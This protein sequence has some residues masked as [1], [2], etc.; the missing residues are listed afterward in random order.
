MNGSEKPQPAQELRVAHV[1]GRL[2]IGGAEKHFVS[3]LNEIRATERW[4]VFTSTPTGGATL[5]DQL[6]PGIEIIRFPVRKRSAFRDVYRLSRRLR[7]TGVNVV[8]THMFWPSLYGVAAARLAGVPVIVTTEHGENRWKKPSHRFLERRVIST[9][10]KRRFCVSE[11]ILK[12]RRDIDHVPEEVLE[13]TVNGTPV[14]GT[15]ARPWSNERPVIGTVGRVVPQ[16]NYQLFV[17][18]VSEVRKR[19]HDVDAYLIG[20]GPLLGEVRAHIAQLN[21]SDHVFTPGISQDVESW[22]RKFD[23]YLI[24]SDQE[25]QPVS[26]LEAMSYGLPIVATDVGAIGK[27]IEHGREGLL[28]EAGNIR[29]LADAVCRFIDQRGFSES[30]GRAARARAIAEFSIEAV[31]RKYEDAYYQILNGD[32]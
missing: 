10:A 8:H 16:K 17:D 23:V 21:L 15:P 26:L 24:S 19:G 9:F 29:Q 27:T 28:G 6:D 25:G 18:V 3:L 11:S 30:C 13:L 1:I 12:A 22:Y 2:S 32:L 5:E 31:A 14:P 7:E 4:A 20:D